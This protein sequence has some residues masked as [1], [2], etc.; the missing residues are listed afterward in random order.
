MKSRKLCLQ[1]HQKIVCFFIFQGSLPQPQV[2]CH[3][4]ATVLVWVLHRCWWPLPGTEG[5]RKWSIWRYQNW[6]GQH[7]FGEQYCKNWIC[8]LFQK[9]DFLAYS[10]CRPCEDTPATSKAAGARPAQFHAGKLILLLASTGTRTTKGS[11]IASWASLLLEVAGQITP[12]P[13]RETECEGAVDRLTGFHTPKMA[14]IVHMFQHN[15]WTLLEQTLQRLQAHP[16]LGQKLLVIDQQYKKPGAQAYH[17]SKGLAKVTLT[18][19]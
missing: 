18:W 9:W 11:R 5:Y 19:A 7:S 16:W 15:E 12:P 14:A 1:K 17:V 13:A 4:R 10:W 2:Q 6:R 8:F 3:Q